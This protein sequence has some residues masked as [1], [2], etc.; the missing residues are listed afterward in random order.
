MFDKVREI[1]ARQLGIEPETISMESRL[2]D[3]LKAD[4]LDIVELVMDLEQEFDVEIPDEDLPKVQ[5]VADIVHFL[6]QR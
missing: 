2:I 3:D 4:S 5:T 1:I 6:E